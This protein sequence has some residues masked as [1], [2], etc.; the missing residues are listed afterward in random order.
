[1]LRIVTEAVPVQVTI[2]LHSYRRSVLVT[3]FF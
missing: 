2:F 1:M 3:D